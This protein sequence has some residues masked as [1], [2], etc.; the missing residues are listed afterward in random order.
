MG[1]GFVI[2]SFTERL[3][4][5]KGARQDT[6]AATILSLLD[7]CVSVESASVALD[8]QGVDYVATLRRGSE[9]FIDAKSRERGCSRF[10]NGNPELAIERWSVMP[11]GKYSQASPKTGWT[12]DEAKKTDMILYTFD[13]SDCDIAFLFPFQSLRIA[14]RRNITEWERRFK[15]DVQDSGSW[16]SQAVFVPAPDVIT[17]VT[18]TFTSL[19][20]K[21]PISESG[22][23][24][25][26]EYDF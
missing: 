3:Q 10:W 23:H 1:A 15:V 18:S 25:P 12:L 20:L 17:A 24:E 8:K 21:V 7:G 4:F 19:K 26:E 11:G 22:I 2:Y 14:A 16:Q 5:S 9:V 6:D 13:P